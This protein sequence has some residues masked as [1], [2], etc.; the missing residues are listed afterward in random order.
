MVNTMSP[1]RKKRKQNTPP[2]VHVRTP[3]RSNTSRINRRMNI[4]SSS[5][6]DSSHCGWND[7]SDSDSRIRNYEINK[8]PGREIYTIDN[9]DHVLKAVLDFTGGYDELY[10]AHRQIFYQKYFKLWLSSRNTTGCLV[11]TQAYNKIIAIIK[12]SFHFT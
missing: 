6:A 2:R 9:M 1:T 11:D 8:G 7:V 5:S 4:D 12:E 10:T 3:L